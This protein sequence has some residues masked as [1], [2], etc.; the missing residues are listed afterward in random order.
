MAERK[1]SK[2]L[3]VSSQ[4][5]RG[6]EMTAGEAWGGNAA[7]SFDERNGKMAIQRGRQK[8]DT[9]FL[10]AERARKEALRARK[11]RRTR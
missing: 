2:V 10:K 6:R 8:K 7:G 5:H 3:G 4:V 11:M 9:E 1:G